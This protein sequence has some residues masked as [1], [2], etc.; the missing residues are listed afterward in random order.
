LMSKV[1]PIGDPTPGPVPEPITLL[2][3]GS[4]LIGLAGFRRK[5]KK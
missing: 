3:V 5:F 4:G 2:L 1:V